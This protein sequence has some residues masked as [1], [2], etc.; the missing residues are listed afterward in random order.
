MTIACIRREEDQRLNSDI[1]VF[2]KYKLL[3][4]LF[5]I[6]LCC[7]EKV[8]NVSYIGPLKV[9]LCSI[10]WPSYFLICFFICP[11]IHFNKFSALNGIANIRPQ[12]SITWMECIP[13]VEYQ[14]TMHTMLFLSCKGEEHTKSVWSE[15]RVVV[16]VVWEVGSGSI[17]GFWVLIRFCF[18]IWVLVSWV[19]SL[20][21]TSLHNILMAYVVFC[22]YFILK[23][24]F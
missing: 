12:N 8:N 14:S 20:C 3:L 9:Y 5:T 19:C 6:Y 23:H 10:N 17:R 21:E 16:T 15:V 18:L 2:S 13:G 22:L 1:C 4:I 24:I 11:F 7:G